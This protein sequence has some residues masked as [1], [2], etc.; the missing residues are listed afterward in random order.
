MGILGWIV[1]GL[2]AGAIAKAIMPGRDPGGI[3]I[4]MLL[5]IVGAIIGGF[6]GRAIFGTDINTFFDLSTWLLA[7]LG[8]LIVLG[9]YRMVT[10][11]R[12]RA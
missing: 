8:S 6:V 1:L 2:I 12:A 7:I 11:N 3:I 10:G 4:T 5:G 9:I